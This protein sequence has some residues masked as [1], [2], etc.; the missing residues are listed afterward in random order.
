MA[1]ALKYLRA[2][3]RKRTIGGEI[4]LQSGQLSGHRERHERLEMRDGRQERIGGCA[5]A[6]LVKLQGRQA[7]PVR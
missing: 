4:H 7:S 2:A 6:A 3:S 1:N 5:Q